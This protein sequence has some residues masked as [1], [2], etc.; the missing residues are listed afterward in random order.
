MIQVTFE[1]GLMRMTMDG[2][3]NAPRVNG[4]DEVCAA[5]SI[6]AYTLAQVAHACMAR[7]QAV[8]IFDVLKEGHAVVEITPQEEHRSS[9]TDKVQVILTGFLLLK[10]YFPECIGVTVK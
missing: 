5:S 4:I 6:L 2:H 3:A 7:G 8:D 9:I 10:E 1:K